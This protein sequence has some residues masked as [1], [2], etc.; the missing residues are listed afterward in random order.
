MS[1]QTSNSE[2]E[3]IAQTAIERAIDT[4]R[5]LDNGRWKK[6]C[7]PIIKRRIING[8]Q[9]L[10]FAAKKANDIQQGQGES[11]PLDTIDQIINTYSQGNQRHNKLMRQDIRTFVKFMCKE[12]RKICAEKSINLFTEYFAENGRMM[13]PDL[14]KR[15]LKNAPEPKF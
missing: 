8:I 2:R 14:V 1:R 7:N 12:Q 9:P 15:E 10:I 5:E 4:V 3:I 6:S 11:S 13:M